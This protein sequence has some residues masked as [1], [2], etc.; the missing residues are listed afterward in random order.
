M[1]ASN[2]A[3]QIFQA[4]GGTMRTSEA[5]GAGIHPRTLYAM[6]DAGE[7]EAVSRGVYRLADMPPLSEPDL[8]AVSLRLPKAVVCL[9]S[10]LAFHDL[11]TQVPHAV[12]LAVPRNTKMPRLQYPPIEVFPFAENAYH[13][14]I[15]TQ[16]IDGVEIKVYSAEKTLA[17][18]FKYRNK[19][20]L[21]IATEALQ[22]YR[23]R[24]GVHLQKVL[25]YA[26]V[27]RV[28]NVI[29]PYLQAI[30]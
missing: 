15:E 2:N 7:L 1:I 30:Q 26:R 22:N 28:E 18:C 8:V 29:R 25:E 14:G 24:K 21:S 20:G 4:H 23:R 5:L 16:G 17:D 3:R 10:A 19:I 6:R 12:Q 11:T 13:T 27:C 9:I